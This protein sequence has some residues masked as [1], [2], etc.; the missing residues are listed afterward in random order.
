MEKQMILSIGREFGSGG[1]L[2]AEK[3]AEQFGLPLYDHE[4]LEHIAEK[5][6]MDHNE[7]KKYDEKP[8]NK[9][10][11][12]TVLG[13]S[14]SLQ[15]T[16]A[17]MQFD[18]LKSK[19]ASG[20]SFVVVGRC[21]EYVLREYDGLITFFITGDCREKLSRTMNQY[22]ISAEEAK[23]LMTRKD[24]TRKSYHN[25]FCKRKW[26][27]T[28]G[29]DLTINSSKLGIDKTAAMLEA[30]IRARREMPAL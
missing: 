23:N 25:Y 19:A 11:S 7:L 16:L 29:Y 4:M 21:S 28:R 17:Q 18:F 9:L 1:H 22:Q 6:Q 8:I 20:E 26:G 2:I 14:S 12:R 24:W 5:K 13:Y 15:E 27:D 10:I 3:L 30:Y